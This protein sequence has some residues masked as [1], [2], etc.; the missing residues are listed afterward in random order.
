[1][2][3]S[4]TG[5]DANVAGL[6]AYLFGWVSG[7]VFFLIE[8]NSVTVRFH[9][10]QSLLLSGAFLALWILVTILSVILHMIK[11]AALA[12]VIGFLLPLIGLAVFAV[13]IICMIKA[14]QNEKLKLPVIGDIAEKHSALPPA[15]PAA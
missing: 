8:K 12:K 6:L 10:L 2:E 11:L 7:L 15:P 1:M 4:S 13:T 9:A 3:K 5:L 14:Y